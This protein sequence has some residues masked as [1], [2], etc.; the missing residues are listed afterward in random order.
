MLGLI[1][2]AS[3]EPATTFAAAYQLTNVVEDGE[4]VHFT[5]TL[6]LNNS[7]NTDIKGGIVV[8]M[9]SGATRT[10][11]GKFTT[12]SDL[13]RLGHIT[14]SE[15]VTVSAA[16]FERWQHGHDPVMKYLVPDDSG[17]V[18]VPIQARRAETADQLAN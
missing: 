14:V 15:E 1:H 12:I 17:A 11:I 10:L 2:T 6:R 3:G 7:T 18:A 13:P 16:E 4:Q 9:N 5:L 8:L